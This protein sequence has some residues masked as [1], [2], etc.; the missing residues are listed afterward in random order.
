MNSNRWSRGCR[1]WLIALATML[2]IL[3][4]IFAALCATFSAAGCAGK[5]IG[6]AVG[7]VEQ[8]RAE[9]RLVI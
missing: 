4:A 5:A 1:T 6:A 7:Y 8:P 3:L 2:F 9:E